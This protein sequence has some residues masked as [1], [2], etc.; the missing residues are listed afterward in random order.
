MTTEISVM[1]GSEKVNIITTLITSVGDPEVAGGG[2]G[3]DS[4]PHFQD[5]LKNALNLLFLGPH[6]Y[7]IK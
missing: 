5:Y 3:G 2:G 7:I 4:D 1:Y 6:L